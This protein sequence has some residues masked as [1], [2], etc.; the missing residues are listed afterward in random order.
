MTGLEEK[1]KG[2]DLVITGE[3]AMDE[4]TYY[5]KSP[6]GVARLAARYNIPVI[7]IN[8]SILAGREKDR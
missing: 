7:T 2:A 3:G 5:G 4:Q 6:F 8:G 1:I